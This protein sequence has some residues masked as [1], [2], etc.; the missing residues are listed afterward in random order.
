MAHIQKKCRSCRV[1]VAEGNRACRECGARRFTYVARYRAPDHTERSRAFPRKIDAERFVADQEHRIAVGAWT[2]PRRGRE[3]LAEFYGRWEAAVV[4]HGRLAPS[5]LAKYEGI[6]RLY[7]EPSLGSYPVARITRK[8]VRDLVNGASKRSPWQAREVLKLVRMLLNR[9][10]DDE[11][12]ARNP[13]VGI[14]APEAERSRVRVLKPWELEAVAANLPERWRAFALLG[15]YASL[16]WSELVAV[17]RDDIQLEGRTLRVDE[18][19][20]EVGGRFE[21]GRPKTR[22]STRTVHL[23]EVAVRPL[24]EHLLRFPPLRGADDPRWEGLVFYGERKGPVRRHVFRPVWDRACRA[25][26]LEDVRPEW[27]RHTG[28][29][30]AYAASKDMKAVAARLG[31]T[32]TR[33]MDT[34]YVEVY[35][36]VSRQVADAIDV[37]VRESTRPG[38]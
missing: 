19:V 28:A 4:E 25:A 30:L 24:A 15:A 5:T 23:P 10:I 21:W 1:S 36:E 27:L 18:K 35:S 38:S 2:D 37:L 31:H 14:P 32:S 26:G 34:V 29:S 11:L 6:W 8:D 22:D 12:I 17:K 7:V 33:M 3:S 13:A 16:R 20:V 9:A